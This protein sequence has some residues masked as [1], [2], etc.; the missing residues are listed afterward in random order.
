MFLVERL[1]P[2][3]GSEICFWARGLGFQDWM[4]VNRPT[5]TA[6]DFLAVLSIPYGNYRKRVLPVA[7]KVVGLGP[8]GSR[9]NQVS[10]GFRAE[11]FDLSSGLGP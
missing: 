5:G 2:R 3:D 11:G 4:A 9:L 1:G 7:I 8:W 6:S 10:Q